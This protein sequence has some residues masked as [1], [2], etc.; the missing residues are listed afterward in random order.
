MI[1]ILIVD[2]EPLSLDELKYLLSHYDDVDVVAETNHMDKALQLLQKHKFDLVFL[3]IRMNNEKAG[4]KIA[5]AIV[6]LEK[7]PLIIFITAYPQ[8]ALKAYDYQPLH[9]LLKPL[10][11]KK[12]DQAIQRA[13]T[14]LYEEM[15]PPPIDVYEKMIDALRS[16]KPS[17]KIAIKYKSQDSYNDTIRPTVYLTPSEILYIHKDKLSNTTK[18]YTTDGQLFEGVRLTLQEFENQLANDDFFRIHTSYIV[19]LDYVSGQKPRAA[20]EENYLVL[21]KG[22]SI[23]LPV[24]KLKIAQLTSILESSN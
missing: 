3:D 16:I 12:L 1:K 9:Y 14:V 4:L 18:V 20:G 7:P 8:H 10:S 5:Q 13:R 15:K 19:N 24:S 6:K 22:N 23:E 21:L 2:D 11:E 17:K